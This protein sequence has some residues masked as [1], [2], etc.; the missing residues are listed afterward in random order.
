MKRVYR[1]GKG[2][3]LVVEPDPRRVSLPA[4][5]CERMNR[6]EYQALETL[7][8]FTQVFENVKGDLM[9]RAG[10]IKNGARRLNSA[11]NITNAIVSD[12]V[13]TITKPQARNLWNTMLD[14]DFRYTLR[15]TPI[16]NDVVIDADTVKDLITC[17]KDKCVGCVEDAD[18]CRECKLYQ[19]LEVITPLDDYGNGMLCPYWKEEVEE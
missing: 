11:Y 17:A 8:A 15:T 3:M 9:K 10:K 1:M 18:S 6:S 19:C 12:I 13:G 14:K 16:G 7:V 2:Q 5:E 4:K